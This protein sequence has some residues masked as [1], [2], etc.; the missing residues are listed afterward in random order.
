MIELRHFDQ[1]LVRTILHHIFFGHDILVQSDERRWLHATEPTL[2]IQID[3]QT[4][5]FGLA[6]FD[7]GRRWRL[8]PID[9]FLINAVVQT[10][11]SSDAIWQRTFDSN[12]IS[13]PK[14]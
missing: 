4:V 8:R 1:L 7:F 2:R 11:G 12:M 3:K 6:L 14:S 5:K 10:P 9:D 13:K